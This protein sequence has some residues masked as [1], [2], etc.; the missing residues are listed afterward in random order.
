MSLASGPRHAPVRSCTAGSPSAYLQAEHSYTAAKLPRCRSVMSGISLAMSPGYNSC[1][2]C[3]YQY[4]TPGLLLRWR[5]VGSGVG[6]VLLRCPQKHG[7]CL[8]T[9]VVFLLPWGLLLQTR[10]SQSQR[11][12]QPFSKPLRRLRNDA[13]IVGTDHALHCSSCIYR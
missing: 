9:G 7:P 11:L 12:S 10:P 6:W 5:A 2:A 13:C 4:Y 8:Q 3:L 1:T